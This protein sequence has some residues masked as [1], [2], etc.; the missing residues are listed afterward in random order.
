MNIEGQKADEKEIS[1]LEGMVV[2]DLVEH[3]EHECHQ[4]N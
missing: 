3:E 1:T 4:F 2:W